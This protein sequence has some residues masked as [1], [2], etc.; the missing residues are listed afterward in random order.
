MVHPRTVEH[1]ATRRA[2]LLLLLA[3]VLLS[4]TPCAVATSRSALGVTPRTQ[5]PHLPP[6][7]PLP[8]PPP[9]PPT[10]PPTSTDQAQPPEGKTTTAI[11]YVYG[12]ILGFCA[13]AI[14]GYC[15]WKGTAQLRSVTKDL[16]EVVKRREF[17]EKQEAAT[18]PKNA[19]A[20]AAAAAAAKDR[21]ARRQAKEAER[22]GQVGTAAL[23]GL[24]LL[25]LA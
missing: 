16:D 9:A 23:G 18:R 5:A 10:P 8:P 12:G 24:A 17:L 21:D 15:M 3:V 6:F 2:P 13:F 20:A 1:T 11:Y 19:A 25:S 4:S 14:L 7:P 22:G